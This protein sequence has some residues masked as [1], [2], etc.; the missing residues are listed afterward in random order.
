MDTQ[1]KRIEELEKKL[2][3]LVEAFDRHTH[4]YRLPNS[5]S[6]NPYPNHDE[7]DEPSINAE[8]KSIR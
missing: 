5:D 8:G 4:Q 1:T 3:A 7:T 6:Q 2:A